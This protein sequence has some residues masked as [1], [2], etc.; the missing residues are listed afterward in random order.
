MRSAETD[1]PQLALPGFDT[2]PWMPKH[3]L[4]FAVMP[5]PGTAERIAHRGSRLA[6]EAGIGRQPHEA[7]RLHVTLQL[8]GDYLHVPEVELARACIAAA[9]V[10]M[11][12][13]EL[14]FDQVLGFK[15]R[16]EHWPLVLM[17]GAGL[18]ALA[19]LQRRLAG[20]SRRG[21]LGIGSRMLPWGVRVRRRWGRGARVGRLVGR[22]RLG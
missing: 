5:D 22:C 2:E 10:E 12:A 13:F 17:P 14:G 11:P 3:R 19:E 7:A 1:T 6:A 4:F 15:G 21:R 18:A 20:W 16:P 9:S 8:V